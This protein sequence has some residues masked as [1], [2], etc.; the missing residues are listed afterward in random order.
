MAKILSKLEAFW[1][2][3]QHNLPFENGILET[4]ACYHRSMIKMRL[5]FYECWKHDFVG[6]VRYPPINTLQSG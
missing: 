4:C 3:I 2:K 6:N 1:L 5:S